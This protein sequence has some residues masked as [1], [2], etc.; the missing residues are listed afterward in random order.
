MSGEA[1]SIRQTRDYALA[2]RVQVI[3]HIMTETDTPGVYVCE[4]CCVR[5]EVNP[6]RN[7][8]TALYRSLILVAK[9]CA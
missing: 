6:H 9:E 1:M 4:R 5:A 2:D 3:D 8:V 7:P